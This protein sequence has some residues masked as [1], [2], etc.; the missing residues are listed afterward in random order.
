MKPHPLLTAKMPLVLTKELQLAMVR[1]FIER[2]R[3]RTRKLKRSDR[4]PRRYKVIK[5][6]QLPKP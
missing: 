6:V 4:H 1:W 5:I 3:L 2:E